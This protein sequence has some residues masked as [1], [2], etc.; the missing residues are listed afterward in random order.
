LQGRR[1]EHHVEIRLTIL[2]LGWRQPKAIHNKLNLGHEY[3]YHVAKI[4]S[5]S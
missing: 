3:E 2:T 4:K 5:S 1:Q